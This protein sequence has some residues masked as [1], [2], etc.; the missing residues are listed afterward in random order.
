M[1]QFCPKCGALQPDGPRCLNCGQ[2]LDLPIRTSQGTW[3]T[4]QQ[5]RDAVLLILGLIGVMLF[6]FGCFVAAMT[7]LGR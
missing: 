4:R 3:V 2:K 5:L 1:P 7:F 6:L